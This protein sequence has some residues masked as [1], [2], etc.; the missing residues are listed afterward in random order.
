MI[1]TTPD[2]AARKKAGSV[3]GKH[4]TEHV[5]EVK[6][7]KK[8]GKVTAAIKLLLRLVDALEAESKVAGPDWPIAPWYYEQLAV[9][10][11][12]EKQYQNEAAI[13][14]RYIAQFRWKNEAP[15][16]ALVARLEK[17]RALLGSR[18]LLA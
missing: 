9:I 7:L 18:F 2:E 11:R 4:F 16:P 17:A 3:S 12:K 1:Y 6:Q 10:Y 5:G 15:M 14:E 8:A 13:I